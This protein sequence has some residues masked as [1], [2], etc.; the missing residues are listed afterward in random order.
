MLREK[1]GLSQNAL[2]RNAQIAQS[3]LSYLESGSKSPSVDTLFRICAAL[4]V[5]IPDFFEIDTERPAIPGHLTSLLEKAMRLNAEQAELLA[6]FLGS[7][8]KQ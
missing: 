4:G 6:Q 5:T 2:A 3:T 7:M 8:T 1:A